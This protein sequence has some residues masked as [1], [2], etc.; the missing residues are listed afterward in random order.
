MHTINK[1][2]VSITRLSQVNLSLFFST[3]S[4]YLS[5]LFLFCISLRIYSQNSDFLFD[6][7]TVEDGL[8]SSNVG[9]IYQDR[10]GYIWFGTYNGVNRFD[11][12]SFTS[13]KYPGD[14][15][16][17]RNE[18]PGSIC[19]DVEGNIWIASHS[20]GLEKLNPQT[21]I[22]TNHLPNSHQP[23][24]HWSNFVLCVYVDRN[25]VMWVGTGNGFYNY[26]RIDKS[27]TSFKHDENDPQSLGHNSVNA[28]H[29]DRSGTI[30]LATGGGLDRFD[31]ESNKFYHYWHYP[32]NGWG[33]RETAMFWVLS[34]LEDNSG[35]IWLGTDE[36]LVE[37]DRKTEKFVRHVYQYNNSLI[38]PNN[39]ILSICEV[40]SESLWLATQG[41]LAIFNK[42]T[43]K[44][45]YQ[46]HDEKNIK[47][48]SSNLLTSILK[49]RSGSIWIST[50]MGGVNKADLPEANFEKYLF[51]PLKDESIASEN[52][53][54]LYESNDET[55]WIAT[56]KGL[57]RF[58]IK[59]R[60]FTG[61]PL[62]SEFS[63]VF[64]DCE[65]NILVSPNIGGL[66]KLT[67]KNKWLSYIDSADGSYSNRFVSFYQRKSGHFWIGNLTGDLYLFDELTHQKKRVANIN[68]AVNVICE[69][70]FGF[71]WFGGIA[72]GLVCY[73]PK[74]DTVFQFSS[75]ADD[76]S[77]LNDDS[78]IIIFEDH[79][80]NLWIGT[81]KGLN[82]YNRDV[83]TFTRF[84]GKYD[85]FADGV[86]QILEDDVN[87]LWIST[88]NGIS[89]FNPITKQSVNYY[90]S[91]QFEGLEFLP[92]TGCSTKDGYMYFGGRKGFIR[93]KPDSV[94]ENLFIPSIVI[95]SFRKYEKPFP[96]G[97]EVQLKHTDNFISFE[98]AALS[99]V[100]SKENQ[101]AYMMEGVDNDWIYCGTRR[102]ASYPNLEPGE[103][104][105]R[106][107]G[108][109]SNRIWNEAGTIVKIIILPPWWK[110]WWAYLIYLLLICSV[111]YSIWRAQLKKIK[112]KQEFEMSKFEAGKLH[113]VDELKSRF[114]TNISHEFRTPLTLILGPAKQLL[115]SINNNEAKDK[116][117]L[118]HRSAKKLNRL[119]DELLDISKIESGEMKLK[120]CP[121]NLVSAVNEI[122]L[123]FYSLAERKRISFKLNS[124][125]DELIVYIDKSKLDKILSN[126]LSNAFKFTPEGGKVEVEIK[127][128]AEL[129][130]AS[131]VQHKIP[132]RV[133][134][135]NFV[136]ICIR[137][138]G[139]GIPQDHLDKIFDRFYQVDGSHTREHEGTG[140][141]LSLTKELVE[142]H[143]GKI[144]VESEEGKGS[145]FRI[146]FILGKEHL[147]PEEIC[148][149]ECGKEYEYEKD[150]EKIMPELDEFL[151]KKSEHK[152]DIELSDNPTL[153]IVED[154]PDVRKY[155]CTIL[156]S[157]YRI[158]EAIDGEEGLAKAFECIPELIISDI[159]MPR[160]DGFQMCSKLKT[161]SRTSHIPIIMLTAKATMQDKISGL[162]IGADEYIMKPFEAEE[163]KARIKNLIEQRKRLHEHFRKYGLVEIEEK[164]I[165]PVDQ[166]FLQNA[167]SLIN[168]HISEAEFGV[169]ELAN[170]MAVSRS[171]LFKKTEALLG[172]S[173]SEFIK[174]TR[175]NKAAKLI[176]KN[177]GNISEIALEVGFNNPS[178]FA[179]CF[180]KQ[181]G[182]AP[183]QYHNVSKK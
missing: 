86:R 21:G 13:H 149:E 29:E 25:K 33:V 80:A 78:I 125:E 145:T 114:F 65:G 115:E 167:V 113:E 101:Y 96:F 12:Y 117:N 56:T 112:V 18:F 45:T 130:S 109:S 53:F 141:G 37:F 180:K 166:K 146:L 63:A 31:R 150:K 179:E 119:V 154:H 102:Y 140:I 148:E 99:Y 152:V 88:R 158:F 4:Y 111:V 171:L 110:T 84:S 156:G 79:S 105:F 69:D 100:N 138:T 169:E 108:S 47:G 131:S 44:F 157:Q 9:A 19:E 62:Y 34:I 39:I 11:G 57:D 137:D 71:L 121:I 116:L 8:S 16:I 133:R 52:I 15:I 24:N 135:D 143:K 3:S 90:S 163:L 36:G 164:N 95:T 147:K 151:E 26:N 23:K 98:F 61:K 144:E 58:D 175:L 2:E 127:C 91:S 128:Q 30:W 139:I 178:Y 170:D 82:R 176:E 42:V 35:T 129:V 10:T 74:Q 81:N 77:T 20:G 177:H 172:E 32:N 160:L 124:N 142:L 97:K 182:V 159:M 103:Y 162:E 153:L 67:N 93:L 5:F 161:D 48:L 22:F 155:I 83:K 183:S 89:R 14:S 7:I 122:A 123:S 174:R 106:V 126:V 50:T 73:D 43:K 66:Y 168:K 6:H 132:K 94:Q 64:Q 1:K 173:P 134:N 41:G 70:A 46:V 68:N 17:I 49:D 59:T 60:K 40:G 76:S 27:F 51:D 118:I 136:E 120:A 104:I 38:R 72:T 55:I 87:N 85:F 107:K 54:S 92:Q 165:T 75:K 28:I 181:F